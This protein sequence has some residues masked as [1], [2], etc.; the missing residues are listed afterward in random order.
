MY[1]FI[2][3]T[4]SEWLRHQSESNDQENNGKGIS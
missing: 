1:I 4:A 3:F 2:F